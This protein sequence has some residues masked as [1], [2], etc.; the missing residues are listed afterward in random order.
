MI[1]IR[2]RYALK[3]VLGMNKYQYFTG[4]LN[5]YFT[6]RLNQYFTGRLM[7]INSQELPFDYLEK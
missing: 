4:R 6:G 1:F 2:I 5:Q 3:L 7:R